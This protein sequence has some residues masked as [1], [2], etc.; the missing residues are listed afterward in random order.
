MDELFRKAAEA[1][2]LNT[3]TANWDAVQAMLG[4]E[5]KKEQPSKGNLRWIVV[6]LP[7]L[8]LGLHLDKAIVT[9]RTKATPTE[10]L[11]QNLAVPAGK[12]NTGAEKSAPLVSTTGSALPANPAPPRQ[13]GGTAML[14]L[15][16]FRLS[17]SHPYQQHARSE[18]PPDE[19]A[20]VFTPPVAAAS[21]TPQNP[22]TAEQ[23]TDPA[24]IAV[25]PEAVA[26]KSS[27]DST[28]QALTASDNRETTKPRSRRK[29]FY[30]GLVGG[31]DISTVKF[32][33]FSNIGFQAG[34]L[35]G[36]AFN[37]RMAV[38]AGALTSEKHYY[39]DGAHYKTDG[40]YSPSYARLVAVD[41]SCRMIELPVALRY[42]ISRQKKGAWF[43]TAGVSSYLMQREDYSL[44][45]LY[46]S[47][48]NIAT[49][50]HTYTEKDQF[51]LA[52]LQ[53]SVGYSTKVG[54]LGNVRV[55]LYYALPLKGMG[56]GRLPVS[57]FGIRFGIT[58]PQF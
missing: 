17:T 29:H 43:A 7:F 58:V 5:E 9:S 33:R 55:E 10:T 4:A 27:V 30:V 19:E 6:L 52:A 38:E 22:G 56:H 2:P 35:V 31:P 21:I 45:Y 51:W 8:L 34:I 49:H 25:E 53:L 14:R 11:T 36:Y 42:T 20:L 37:D 46:P 47:S 26:N 41:G 32:Q 1:Y 23:V 13:N 50:K 40:Y 48:G 39:S 54:S 15:L 28:H 24:E 44:D 57:S 12:G 3:G 16:P 18:N